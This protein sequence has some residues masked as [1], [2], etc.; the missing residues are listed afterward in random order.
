MPALDPIAEFRT[1]WLPHVSDE[2]LARITDLLEK[3]SPLLIHGAFT[4]AVPMG[5]RRVPVTSERTTWPMARSS[6]G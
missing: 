2:G 4:R 6:L 5:C 1:A 3:A